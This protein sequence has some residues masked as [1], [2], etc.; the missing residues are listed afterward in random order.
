MDNRSHN[1]H[2]DNSDT[3]RPTVSQPSSTPWRGYLTS[4]LMQ[5]AARSL[6]R[7]A[8]DSMSAFTP[9]YF[10]QIKYCIIVPISF[11]WLNIKKVLGCHTT[12]VSGGQDISIPSCPL[13][14]GNFR[15]A[16][17]LVSQEKNYSLSL[18]WGRMPQQCQHAQSY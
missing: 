9:K 16:R 11:R 18:N 8:L 15:K 3:Q 6:L 14:F 12:M 17:P 4:V 2:S 1:N 5:S 13:F 10:V 7:L